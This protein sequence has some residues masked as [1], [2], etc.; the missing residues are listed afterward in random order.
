MA[1]SVFDIPIVNIPKVRPGQPVTAH[2]RNM[3]GDAINRIR[4]GVSAVAQL[5]P[6]GV[7]PGT[8]TRFTIESIQPFFLVCRNES[9]LESGI[10]VC[11]PPSAWPV[12]TRNR[13]GTTVAYSSFTT[14]G[15]QCTANSG[16]I[17]E[18]LIIIEPY[19]VGDTI[20]AG[21]IAGGTSIGEA[22][23]WMELGTPRLWAKKPSP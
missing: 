10:P 13:Y 21:R 8:L 1:K 3:M 5:F 15:T 9:T 12:L 4:Q 23:D 18:F 6:E 17:T 11:K 22:P 19:T 16:S 7:I 20:A 2:D 14:D